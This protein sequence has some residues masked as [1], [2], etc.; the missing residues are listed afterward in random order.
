MK[1]IQLYIILS[2][3]LLNIQAQEKYPVKPP[4]TIVAYNPASTGK[5]LGSP[6]ICILPDG[7]YL[8]AHDFFGKK[9]SEDESVI[10]KSTDKGKS[11]KEIA[12]L[13]Q[14]WSALF[15]HKGS[16][17]FIGTIQAHNNYVIRKS[18][19]GGYTWTAP[20]DENTGIIVKGKFHC[21]PTPIVEH[22]GRLWRALEDA[23]GG[24]EW[25][26][27]YG[28]FL[29]SASVDS[30]LLKAESWTRT[31]AVWY[32]ESFLNHE[33]K[34]W[35]EGNAVIDK[36]GQV[37]NLIRVHT[38]SKDKE[39]AAII[40]AKANGNVSFN[41]SKDFIDL[42][43]GS[44]KFT[45]RYDNQTKRY[46]TLVNYVPE[47]YRGKEQMDRIRN[48]LVLCSSTDLLHWDIHSRLLFHPDYK[49]HG[50]QYADWVFD[51]KDIIFLS[52]T[53]YDDAEGG[54]QNYH[55][56]NYITFHRIKKIKKEQKRLIKIIK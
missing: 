2:F 23:E 41:P 13:R 6:S 28:A 31:Q 49:K 54:A 20:T 50:F 42:P 38:L 7:S 27:R 14:F 32:N 39:Y 43:G 22:N 53:A 5:Y 35:L 44:K 18:T 55:N 24:T 15:V 19:D 45:V 26:K 34:G 4:G 47:A 29:I 3:L 11:W 8:A 25:P 40:H 33:F 1:T 10:Y 51:G 21:A 46:W 16:V 48:T 17:Y 56:T 30:D 52:R 9:T 37:A 36:N 12:R